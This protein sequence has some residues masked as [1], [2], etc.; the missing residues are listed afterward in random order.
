MKRRKTLWYLWCLG[1]F[2]G[3]IGFVLTGP[4][5]FFGP[6]P[7][8]LTVFWVGRYLGS[9]AKY[10]IADGGLQALAFVIGCAF[11]FQFVP[12]FVGLPARIFLGMGFWLGTMIVTYSAAKPPMPQKVLAEKPVKTEP[13]KRRL[14][15]GI[16]PAHRCAC[17]RIGVFK[18]TCG[19]QS[20]PCCY[21]KP[22][23][24]AIKTRLLGAIFR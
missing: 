7:F 23:H 6:I 20:A 21:R 18:V 4:T 19:S 24:E 22:C 17:G 3:I 11:G 8:M 14:S 9:N 10:R 5:A 13:I 12:Q 15:L 16:L 2:M 1:Y